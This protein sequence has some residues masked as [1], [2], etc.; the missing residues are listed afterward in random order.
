MRSD[1]HTVN[2]LTAYK[3]GTEQTTT[4]VVVYIP[5][6]ST[7]KCYAG[8]RVFI[9]HADDSETEI[10]SGTPVA[11]VSRT[12]S[13]G[14]IQSNTWNCPETSLADTDAIVVRVYLKS[15]AGAWS[16]K[17]VFTT[18][19]LNALKLDAAT[20]TVYYYTVKYSGEL[21]WTWEFDFGTSTYNS[22]IA[23]FAW[24]LAA[25]PPEE[26]HDVNSWNFQLYARKWS[27]VTYSSFDL[28]A[29]KWYD[30]AQW[31]L[32]I[33]TRQWSDVAIWMFNTAARTWNDIALWTLNLITKAWHETS[34]WIFQIY[35]K[36]WNDVLWTLQ[37]TTYEWH[38]IIEWSFTLIS[39]GWHTIATWIL[40][41]E[42]TVLSIILIL[43]IIILAICFIYAV[44]LTKKS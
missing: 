41:I 44:W 19:Q 35:T 42:T 23:N 8:I 13:G 21:G 12:S 17:A 25:P 36:K 24:T 32:Q 22:R 30:I 3:L 6:T 27:D 39:H 18:E 5:T 10:T 9:R 33:L 43:G 34:T 28:I 20:W 29:Q 7:A 38:T 4:P 15:G 14:G 31:A 16:E 40:T 2:G 26:W 11:Q 37:L 1:Q